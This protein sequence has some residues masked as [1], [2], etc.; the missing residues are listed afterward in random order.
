MNGD[1]PLNDWGLDISKW[2]DEEE[3]PRL[4]KTE[5][6]RKLFALNVGMNLVIKNCNFSG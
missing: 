6:K 1:L 2:T 3:E 4:D 5:K